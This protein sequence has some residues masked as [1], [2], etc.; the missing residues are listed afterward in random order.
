LN[1]D[2]ADP[3]DPLTPRLTQALSARKVAIFGASSTPGKMGHELVRQLVEGGYQG[4]LALINPRGGSVCGHPVTPDPSEGNGADV[5]VIAT[6]KER[7]KDI[8]ADCG[9][10]NIP[11]AIVCAGGYSEAGDVR[12]EKE[13][14]DVARRHGVSILGPNC[15]GV[16]AADAQL[17]LTTIPSLPVGRVSAIAQSGGV[18][19]QIAHRLSQLGAGFDTLINLGNKGGLDFTAALGAIDSREKTWATLLYMESFDEGDRFLSALSQIT[20]HL[21]VVVALG[22]RTE[23]GAHSARSHTGAMLTQ[24]DRLTGVL[25]GHGALVAG[26]LTEAVAAA[27]A[28]RRGDPRGERGSRR[29]VFVASDGGGLATLAADALSRAGFVLPRLSDELRQQLAAILGMGRARPGNP[30]DFAGMADR[31]PGLFPR[32]LQ[33]AHDSGEFDGL[34]LVGA[35]GSYS[36]LYGDAIGE[37]EVQAA[38]AIA[39]LGRRSRLPMLAQSTVAADASAPIQIIREADIPCFEW[40]E[41]VAAGLAL[42]LR[43]QP[44]LDLRREEHEPA[45]PVWD[46]ELARDTADVLAVFGRLHIPHAIGEVVSRDEI[47]TYSGERWVLRLD[48]FPHKTEAGAIKVVGDKEKLGAFDE[49]TALAMRH[50][51]EPRIRIAPFFK[52]TH[53]LLV[54]F[55]QSKEAGRGWAIGSGGLLAERTADIQTSR[56][57]VSPQNVLEALARTRIGTNVLSANPDALDALVSLL[58]RLSRVFTNDL[59]HLHELECNPVAIGNFGAAV[60]DVLPIRAVRADFDL[61]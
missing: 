15:I 17:N 47:V 3:L 24:W 59:A 56:F 5:A 52:H 6:S 13:L 25:E 20:P 60:L 16:F 43:P 41:E 61:R 38:R 21:P 1:D 51:A 36:Q 53:E 35:L 48:G 31:D 12:A 10:V 40:P 26:T 2:E 46:A 30:L 27:A 29:N 7:V 42:R 45:E 11:L 28:G 57:P 58:L 44:P 18:S 14:L 9:K 32:A 34:I 50:G 4:E 33:L 39:D 54:T 55:W 8:I 23:A 19:F 22:G 37:L 49:L